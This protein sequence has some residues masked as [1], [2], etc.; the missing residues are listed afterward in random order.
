VKGASLP[1][2]VEYGL[3]PVANLAAALVVSGLVILTIGESPLHALAV[4]VEG[5]VG[6]PEAIGFTLFYATGFIFTGLAVALPFHAGLFN[7]GGEGQAYLGGLGVA[8]VCLKLA[9]L[10]FALVLPLAVLA[11]MLFGALWALVPAWLQAWRGSHIVITTIMFNFIASAL[12]TYLLVEVL[13]APGQAAPESLPFAASVWLP[14]LQ[15]LLPMLGA[16]PLNVAFPLALICCFLFWLFLWRTR[17]GYAIRA[18]GFNATAA[19]YG[20][21][22][23]NATIVLSM[24]IGGAFAGLMALNEIMGAQHRLLLNFTAGAGF[25]GIAVA[26]M[27]RNH[28]V[29]I[30]LAAILFGALYQGGAELA[31]EMPSVRRE[32]IVVIEGLVI[33]FC[34]ALEHLFRAPLETLFRR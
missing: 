23:I 15:R 26:L 1:G 28:P 27:G 31:F 30:V 3:L 34:G 32:L 8:L 9:A 14:T 25:V 5:A 13:I 11:A 33:L 10:P 7:I 24:G 19:R 16:A 12:M 2:W 6:Y 17:W 21:I 29:G 22:S 20:G 4:L 18:A